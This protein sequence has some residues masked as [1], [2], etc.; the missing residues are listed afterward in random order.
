MNRVISA[1]LTIVVILSMFFIGC[2]R[3][4]KKT[5]M[6]TEEKQDT[7]T[8]VARVGDG[9]ITSDEFKRYLAKRPIHPRSEEIKEQIDRRLETL[10]LE[11]V[12]YQEALRLQLDKESEVQERIRQILI[13]KLINDQINEKVRS[14]EISTDKLK[15]FYDKHKG[16][17]NRPTQV[18]LAD[19]YIAVPSGAAK[20]VREQQRKKAQ[21]ILAK[22]QNLKNRR[23]GFG[24]LIH[25]YSDTPEKYRKGDT[26][27]FDIEGKPV[28][29]DT[30]LAEAAF[31][32][33]KVG[34]MSEQVIETANG[35]HV[36]LLIGRRNAV[37]RP[38]Q[39]VQNQIRQQIQHDAINETREAYLKKL[40]DNADIAIDENV[41][42][43]IFA[44]LGSN[45]SSQN[46]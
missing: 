7:L 11:E 20:T 10:I 6:S 44:E 40:K 34:S 33:N 30:Q 17:F 9:R 38:L 22:V 8:I 32:L 36:V 35:F 15:E 13:Q 12:L 21:D 37:N 29:I 18:R 42:S 28:G 16:K 19:I 2:S 3:D 41:L 46:K 25:Q 27:F 14:R 24:G 39:S 45:R 5:K 23:T 26:G 1:L 31:K 43:G 4:E